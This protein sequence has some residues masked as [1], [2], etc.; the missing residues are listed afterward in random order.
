M[1]EDNLKVFIIVNLKSFRY[2]KESEWNIKISKPVVITV[3]TIVQ[4]FANKQSIN[5]PIKN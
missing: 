2:F 4:L 1:K 3:Q 5:C